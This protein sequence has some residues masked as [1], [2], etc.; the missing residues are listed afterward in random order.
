VSPGRFGNA[1]PVTSGKAVVVDEAAEVEKVA[2]SN[3]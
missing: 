3:A 2:K 1:A